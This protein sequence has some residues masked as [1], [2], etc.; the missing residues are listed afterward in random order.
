MFRLAETIQGLDDPIK[1]LASAVS[2]VLHVLSIKM[3]EVTGQLVL[4]S[5]EKKFIQESDNS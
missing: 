1:R 4:S 2:S 3:H 5:E